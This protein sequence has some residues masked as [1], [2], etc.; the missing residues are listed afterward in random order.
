MFFS[1]YYLIVFNLL[2]L[3]DYFVF[4]LF[5]FINLDFILCLILKKSLICQC[6]N[7]NV[8]YVFYSTQNNT[9]IFSKISLVKEGKIIK[10]FLYTSQTK[11]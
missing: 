6:H 8:T 4:L 1:I 9:K 3:F 7:A 10:L 5:F 2:S 11:P